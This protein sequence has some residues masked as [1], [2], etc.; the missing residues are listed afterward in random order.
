MG[1]LQQRDPV[2][3][4]YLLPQS[5]A[6]EESEGLIRFEVENL[7][8]APGVIEVRRQAPPAG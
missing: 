3:E 8:F 5:V 4:V 6:W 7:H 1:I 2:E